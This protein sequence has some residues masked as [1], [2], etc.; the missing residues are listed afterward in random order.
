MT[1]AVNRLSSAECNSFQNAGEL[2]IGSADYSRLKRLCDDKDVLE[3]DGRIDGW[4][5]E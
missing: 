4:M 1:T 5:D 3:L 2:E